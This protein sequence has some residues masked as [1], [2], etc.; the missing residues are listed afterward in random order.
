[1]SFLSQG[2]SAHRVV[3]G[4]V[5]FCVKADGFRSGLPPQPSRY[6]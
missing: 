3:L 2:V 5:P 6:F 1:M 4:N